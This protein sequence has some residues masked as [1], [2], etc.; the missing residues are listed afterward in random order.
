M[1]PTP[2]D[3]L[4]VADLERWPVWRFVTAKGD[5]TC[6]VPS[7]AAPVKSLGGYVVATQVRLRDGTLKWALIGNASRTSRELNEHLLTI[8]IEHQGKWMTLARY[9]DVGVE[10]FGP[11]GLAEFLGNSIDGV[12]PIRFDIR[13]V[14]GGV[15]PALEGEINKEPMR[16]LGRDELIR[17]I[18]VT[19][20]D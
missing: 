18:V 4:R 7:K 1:K 6:V 17:L 13:K 14:V 20:D 2:V 19:D 15:C 8:S 16:R 5:E 11:A 9:H 3:Q 12:F 10:A